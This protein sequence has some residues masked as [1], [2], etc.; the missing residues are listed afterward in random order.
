VQSKVWYYQD[1]FKVFF[2]VFLHFSV[3]WSPLRQEP[4][5]AKARD[6]SHQSR[7]PEASKD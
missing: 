5:E 6:N 1:D 7:F 4:G 3:Q 2:D